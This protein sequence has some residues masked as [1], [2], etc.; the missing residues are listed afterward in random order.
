MLVDDL[1]TAYE[2][3]IERM[4]VTFGHDSQAVA[5]MRH[6]YL[7]ALCDIAGV[8]PRSSVL[9]KIASVEHVLRL[10]FE[11][12]LPEQPPPNW[13]AVVDSTIPIICFDAEY[14]GRHYR[15]VG[16][17]VAPD[18]LCLD[19]DALKVVSPL[20]TYMYVIDDVERLRVYRESFT[21]KELVKGRNVP[22]VAGY[23]VTHAMLVPERLRAISAGEITLVGDDAVS[24]VIANTKS[25]HFQP[26]PSSALATRRIL[27]K[28][29]GLPIDHVLVFSNFAKF[30]E[31]VPAAAEEQ[32]M[33]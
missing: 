26:P 4:R 1:C 2:A 5:F 7:V 14:Y 9:R 22:K 16:E 20:E 12:A 28:T 3:Q 30:H 17:T 23:P 21:L 6:Q 13:C 25:G 29:F 18:V 8:K 24:W 32:I 33:L 15:Q 19:R 31:S 11:S 10:Q 27:S